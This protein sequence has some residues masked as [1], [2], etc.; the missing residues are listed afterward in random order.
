MA[1]VVKEQKTIDPIIHRSLTP[2]WP[3]SR[4]DSTLRAVLRASVFEFMKRKDVS[5][6]VILSE[7]VEI[8]KAFFDGD[9]SKMVNAV[10]DTIARQLRADEMEA[11]PGS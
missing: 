10:L 7:Y 1:G 3:L 9:E 6:K 2:D 5:A 8:T 4:I 11:K